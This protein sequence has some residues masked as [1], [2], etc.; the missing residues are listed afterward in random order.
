M[1]AVHLYSVYNVL[2]CTVAVFMCT[3]NDLGEQNLQSNLFNMFGYFY[4]TH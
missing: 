1:I 3:I 4:N 2:F